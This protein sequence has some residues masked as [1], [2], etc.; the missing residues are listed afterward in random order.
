MGEK[1]SNNGL[2]EILE[3]KKKSTIEIKGLGKSE[4][5]SRP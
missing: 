2:A 3:F 1:T 4:D 5:L